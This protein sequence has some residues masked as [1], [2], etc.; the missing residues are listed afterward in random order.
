MQ[1]TE[2]NTG[3]KTDRV[4]SDTRTGT[5]SVSSVQATVCI[6]AGARDVSV[7]RVTAKTLG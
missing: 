1:E 2:Q 5:S 6:W 4:L 3:E 7:T